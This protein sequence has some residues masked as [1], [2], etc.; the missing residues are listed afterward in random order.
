MSSYP[1]VRHPGL[2]IWTPVVLV[3]GIATAGYWL[4]AFPT[5]TWWDNSEYSAAA[6]TLGVPHPPGSLLATII[7]WL[8]AKL[9]PLASSLL[10]LNL[11]A[12]L[13]AGLTVG[14]ICAL[15]FRLLTGMGPVRG[16]S[17]SQSISV[18]AAIGTPVAA[19]AFAFGDTMW[20]YAVKFTPYV[21]TA[22]FTALIL[23][24]MLRWWREA[25]HRNAVRWLLVIAVLFGLDFSVHRTNLLLLPGLLFWV[26]LRRPHVLISGRCWLLGLGGFVLALAFN[27]LII[28]LAAS[29][30]IL[31]M[32]DPSSFS[33]YW[34]YIALQQ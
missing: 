3:V 29:G 4:T 32:G 22:L 17:H 27:M 12:G 11:L 7:G 28:P 1:G 21:L 26:L 9:T 25:E 2:M 14:L 13:L 19:F 24:A 30:P 16:R 10:T 20:S 18:P 31:N 6:V 15:A 23:W 5:L 33:R 34:N 8:A